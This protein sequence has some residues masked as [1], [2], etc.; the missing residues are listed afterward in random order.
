MICHDCPKD[1]KVD[2]IV[3]GV[4]LCPECAA[5]NY[6]ESDDIKDKNERPER[7]EQVRTGGS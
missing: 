5:K 6:P 2:I 4:R 7:A 3:N 1:T